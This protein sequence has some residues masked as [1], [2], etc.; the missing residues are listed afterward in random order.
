MLSTTKGQIMMKETS[1]QTEC[2]LAA[3]KTTGSTERRKFLGSLWK[4]PAAAGLVSAIVPEKAKAAPAL[5]GL[6]REE[7]RD[8]A[9]AIRTQTAS[10]NRFLPLHQQDVSGDEDKYPARFSTFTRGLRHNDLG[11]ADPVAFHALMR[12][13]I[14]GDAADFERI[15]MGG[16][17][18]LVSP[19]GAYAYATEGCDP[20]QPA[21]RPTPAFAS[22][23]S[24]AELTEL[25][26]QSLMR[27][28]PFD[29]YRDSDLAN[30]A[31]SDL[32][33]MSDFRGAKVRGQVMPESLF[34]GITPGDLIGPYVS[35]FLLK[36]VPMGANPYP[37]TLRPYTAGVDYM[38]DYATWLNVQ[39]GRPS[40]VRQEV[41]SKRRHIQNGRDLGA[42][43]DR[44]FPYQAAMGASLML[45]SWGRSFL[46]KDNPYLAY[47]KQDPFSNFGGP[48]ILDAV[49]RVCGASLKACWFQ[50]WAVHRKIRPEG[51]AGRIHNNY[52]GRTNYPFHS[53]FYRSAVIAKVIEK[54][55]SLLLSQAFFEGSPLH[56]AYPAGHATFVGAGITAVKAMFDEN[57]IIPNPVQVSD[58]GS[59]LIPWDGPPLTV[60]GELNKMAFN[61]S[62]GRNFAG[63][64][65]RSDA[66]VGMEL[67]ETFAVDALRDKVRTF[68]EAFS[69]YRITKLDGRPY[70]ISA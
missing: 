52:A 2:V 34:R 21:I 46:D 13:I 31:A 35:Q 10:F 67:G 4:L 29:R 56:P 69:G 3:Q 25:Y 59:S 39:R 23:E 47:S 61:V 12:A 19:Q 37:Q 43:V 11:E 7:R 60:G 45:L 53:D 58:D 48:D 38:T 33:R 27:D 44:D 57:A 51:M 8:A 62:M 9:Y 40:G 66:S 64:H 70:I 68:T 42:W 50:K 32:N 30:Q 18:R 24:A 55:N 36:E 28:V 49:A 20:Q 22:A 5:T 54:Q 63:I 16:A 65:Y 6:S 17:A 15:P 1:S 41:D 26:W 14:S